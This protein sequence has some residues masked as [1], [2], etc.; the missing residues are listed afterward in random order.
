MWFLQSTTATLR[1]VGQVAQ[2][3]TAHPLAAGIEERLGDD[4]A[5]HPAPNT[6]TSTVV[7]TSCSNGRYAYAIE[8]PTV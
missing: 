3:L 4:L 2:P 5:G 6:S 8:R 7:P 1:R